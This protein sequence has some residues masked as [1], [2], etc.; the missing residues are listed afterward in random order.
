MKNPI[1]A[2]LTTY[3]ADARLNGEALASLRN[4][5]RGTDEQRIGNP[6]PHSRYSRNTSP[7]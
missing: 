2:T 3:V 6:S 4:G 7:R 5:W 1:N